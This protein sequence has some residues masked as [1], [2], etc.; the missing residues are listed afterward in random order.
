MKASA[1][2]ETAAGVEAT[3][4]KSTTTEAAAT[5]EITA[6]EPARYRT[7]DHV[8]LE[9]PLV[10]DLAAGTVEAQIIRRNWPDAI[11]VAIGQRFDCI[12]VL[13]DL[14]RDIRMLGRKIFAVL[15]QI[16]G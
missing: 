4:A 10:A 3:T 14:L 11:A 1:S 16:V 9:R 5:L 7:A 13:A 8:L 12:M 15:F 2:M 6:I